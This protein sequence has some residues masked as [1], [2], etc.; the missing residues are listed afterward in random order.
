MN[1]SLL[2][3]VY[4]LAIVGLISLLPVCNTPVSAQNI[5][6][7]LPGPF[8]FTREEY[9][10]GNTA[11]TP[12][13]FPPV[14]LRGS[15]HYPKNWQGSPLPLIVFLHGKHATC[16]QESD[17]SYSLDWPCVGGKQ[18][19]PSFNGYDYVAQVLASNGYFVV[20]ISANGISAKDDYASDRGA[21]A[22]AE[23]IQKHLDLWKMF[24][25]TGGSPFGTKFIGK[26]DMQRI[27]TMGHSRGGEGVAKHFLLNQS[28]GSPYGIKAVFGL[29]PVNFSRLP[30]N[31]V[32]LA[33]LLPYCDGDV[34]DMQGVHFYDDARYIMD[35]TTTKHMI[36]VLGANHNFYNTV[37]TPSIFPAGAK[38]DFG[39]LDPFCKSGGIGR[40]TEAQQQA[41]GIMYISAFFRAYVGGESQFLPVLTTLASPLPSAGTDKIYVSFHA[42]GEPTSRR[43]VNKLLDG[44]HLSFNTL[45]GAV[46]P[47]LL[48]PYNICGGESAEAQCLTVDT[49][50]QPHTAPSDFSMLSGLSQLKTGWNT[51]SAFL[52]NDLPPTQRNLTFFQ[53]LQFRASVNFEDD[54]NATDTIQNFR[55]ALTDGT[56]AT[57]SIRVSDFSPALFVP[58]GDVQIK[59]PVPKVILNTVRLPL[60]AFSQVNLA[61]IHSVKFLF[62][63]KSQGA[64]LITDIAFVSA[65]HISLP[66]FSSDVCMKD[67][68]SG[69]ELMFNTLTGNYIFCYAGGL[70][71]RGV[72]K[73][74][75]RG[76]TVTL[77]QGGGETDRRIVVT[78][79]RSVKKGTASLQSPPGNVIC[80]I[81]DRNTADNTC[82]C[83]STP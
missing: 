28:L 3:S 80:T 11:F 2:I 19:I 59:S 15:V 52:N 54:R 75:T 6:P 58:P 39:D 42:P 33:V 64:L 22:R 21:Q 40:L 47:N 41:T 14:E 29:A 13:G 78:T 45:G 25:T 34:T 16:Y 61:D 9:D 77:T 27:G 1:K 48:D 8:L 43:D 36:L 83:G 32:S 23:L 73:V 66:I 70:K 5:D 31:K 51:T 56:G 72:G 12:T 63:E 35:D 7:T 17:L 79:D 81:A 24:N 60:S 10:F 38:D 57:A 18:P 74:I 76:N 69:A 30:I 68:S 55:V 20:S 4:T 50:Q 44:N 46:T 37:W 82:S 49:R 65:A 53:A 26:I 62:D 71:M 67:D